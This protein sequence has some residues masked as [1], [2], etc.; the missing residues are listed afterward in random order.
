M[1]RTLV[2]F[3]FP[4]SGSGSMTLR[5][6]GTIQALHGSVTDTNDSDRSG[7]TGSRFMVIE[8]NERYRQAAL[9]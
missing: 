8:F 2:G 5:Y 1:M 7:M 4:D 3:V 9:L 6:T